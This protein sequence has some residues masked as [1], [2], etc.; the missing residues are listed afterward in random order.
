MAAAAAAC[1]AVS[2]GAAEPCL[3]ASRPPVSVSSSVSSL[4]SLSSS[5]SALG[6]AVC[7]PVA[8]PSPSPGSGSEGWQDGGGGGLGATCATP[9]ILPSTETNGQA[10]LVLAWVLAFSAGFV[11][12]TTI[13]LIRS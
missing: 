5:L 6:A 11:V 10:L 3:A 4:S 1:V 2:V 9:V 12:V 7:W 8:S 13:P